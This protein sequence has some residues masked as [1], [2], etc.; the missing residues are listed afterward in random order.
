MAE[1]TKK[2]LNKIK[3]AAFTE[4]KQGF[5]EEELRNLFAGGKNVVTAWRITEGT[6]NKIVITQYDT[7]IN[8]NTLQQDGFTEAATAEKL[9]YADR[10][11]KTL[12]FVGRM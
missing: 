4:F 7:Q 2:A 5:S 3:A 12:E 6:K 9:F 1:M 11:T 10:Q 8:T